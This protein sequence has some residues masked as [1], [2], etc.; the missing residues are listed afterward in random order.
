MR[1]PRAWHEKSSPTLIP[2][3]HQLI[4]M[5][6]GA[7]DGRGRGLHLRQRVRRVLDGLQGRVR[8]RKH[9]FQAVRL[10]SGLSR[11]AYSDNLLDPEQVMFQCQAKA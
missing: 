2:N 1:V 3:T 7:L 6:L 5:A 8:L 9:G 4:V 10:R 11:L